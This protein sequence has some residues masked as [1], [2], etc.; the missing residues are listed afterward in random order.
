MNKLIIYSPTSQQLV[1]FSHKNGILDLNNKSAKRT[2]CTSSSRIFEEFEKLVR[3]GEASL[4]DLSGEMFQK[5]KDWIEG[6]AYA[7]DLEKFGM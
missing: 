5:F 4:V 6:R 2:R 7:S 1:I 3:S